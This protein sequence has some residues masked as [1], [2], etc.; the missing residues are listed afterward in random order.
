MDPLT[1]LELAIAAT[2]HGAGKRKLATRVRH[3]GL[4]ALSQNLEVLDGASRHR[5]R[6]EA[7]Q[8]AERGTT[9]FLRGSAQ[10]PRLLDLIENAPPVLFALG[11]DSLLLEPGIGVCGARNVSGD[12]VQAAMTCGQTAASQG[13]VSV[14]GY[15]R[16]VDMATHV[17]TLRAGGA[18][19][20]VLPEG[21]DH[22]RV[23]R[24]EFSDAWDP[25]RALVLSQFS[26]T[27]PWTTGGAMTRNGVII[28]LSLALV[29]VEAG[30]T[31]GTLAA[32]KRA[33]ELGRR[34]IALEFTDT[35]RGN[36]MLLDRGAV[37]AADKTELSDFLNALRFVA[38]EPVRPNEVDPQELLIPE[39]PG[40]ARR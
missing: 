5:V 20:I 11:N 4:D 31:G 2:K 19:I 36:K 29:V 26:P 17:S 21:I 18:T 37:A 13:L 7:E 14:S 38:E 35:P 15:A 30:E 23:K 12:G 1:K 40:P 33:L 28:G 27:Q 16:G 22:F 6:D 10:Y 8:L 39:L 34:V 9:A 25:S 32:G 24:G 3:G